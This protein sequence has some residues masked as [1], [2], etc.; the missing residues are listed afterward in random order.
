MAVEGEV[1]T[2]EEEQVEIGEEVQVI[3]VTQV[4]QE[5]GQGVDRGVVREV[6]VLPCRHRGGEEE[7]VGEEV[8]EIDDDEKDDEGIEPSSFVP[9]LR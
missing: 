1:V 7:V 6:G 5:V 2:A 3:A 4:A 8:G 9:C